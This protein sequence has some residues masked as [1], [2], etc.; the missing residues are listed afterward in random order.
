MP[1][2]ACRNSVSGCPDC[3]RGRQSKQIFQDKGEVLQ[4]AIWAI[5]ADK[6]LGLYLQTF[7]C[8]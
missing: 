2:L 1:L 7:A 5:A 6:D 4:T 8:R 3:R